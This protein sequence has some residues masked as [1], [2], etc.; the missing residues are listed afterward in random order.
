MND[1]ERKA[2]EMILRAQTP[3]DLAAAQRAMRAAFVC[4]AC[5]GD[6]K[7]SFGG[8]A[9]AVCHGVGANASRD[10]DGSEQHG[11]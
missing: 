5:W 10:L 9:C 6:G 2:V 4:R 3:D 1:E 7:S 11:R 8:Q